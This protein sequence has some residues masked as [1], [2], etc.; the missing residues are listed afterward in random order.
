METIISNIS[1]SSQLKSALTSEKLT[2][3]KIQSDLTIT[4]LDENK[5][6]FLNRTRINVNDE[7]VY[8]GEAEI[9]EFHNMNE[10]LKLLKS[11]VPEPFLTAVLAVWG[12]RKETEKINEREVLDDEQRKS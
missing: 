4:W 10:G 8:I 3:N 2:E 6:C 12:I 11:S 9:Q 1:K 7:W 5:V